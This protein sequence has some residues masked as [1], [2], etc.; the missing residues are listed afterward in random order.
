ME[1]YSK[2]LTQKETIC[3][4][5]INEFFKVTKKQRNKNTYKGL[6]AK[7][8]NEKFIVYITIHQLSLYS[9]YQYTKCDKLK[10]GHIVE[11]HYIKF[12]NEDKELTF[13]QDFGAHNKFANLD[14]KGFKNSSREYLESIDEEDVEYVYLHEKVSGSMCIAVFPPPIYNINENTIESSY[15]DKSDLHYIRP[16]DY[17]VTSKN[18]YNN[19][20]SYAGR[21]TFIE[22][23]GYENF[24]LLK[25]KMHKNKST[26]I[27]FELMKYDE[28]VFEDK[29]ESMYVHLID[30]LP[31]NEYDLFLEFMLPVVRTVYYS[32]NV[33]SAIKKWEYDQKKKTELEGYVLTIKLKDNPKIIKV[34]LKFWRYLVFREFRP[35]VL[36]KFLCP[37]I[38]L[39][40]HK[41]NLW[42]VA[43]D[44]RDYFIEKTI[45]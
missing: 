9:D 13:Y 39:M 44:K 40:E 4:K 25:D 5:S 1:Y 26:T 14:Q 38:E 23:L 37:S 45:E 21:K 22:T 31:I 24:G 42:N 8:E 43:L 7:I 12:K 17:Y 34:K 41:Y 11:K 10:R 6:L 19:E 16:R 28:H 27:V 15:D 30:N 18:G 32:T 3:L 20:Y 35:S 33:K 2:N 29:N 36:N